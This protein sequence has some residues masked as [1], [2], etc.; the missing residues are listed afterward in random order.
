MGNELG[1]QYIMDGN[2]NYY[3]LGGNGQLIVAKDRNEAAVFT[4][5]EANQ[6]IGD[7]KKAKFYYTIPVEEIEETEKEMSAG[8]GEIA[9]VTCADDNVSKVFNIVDKMQITAKEQTEENASSPT[10]QSQSE[11]AIPVTPVKPQPNFRYSM[12]DTDWNE[13]VNYYIFLASNIKGYQE[14]LTKQESDIDKTICDLLHYV[15][16]YDLTDEEGLRAMDLLKDARQRRRDVKNELCKADY[17]QKSI[18]SSANVAKAKGFLTQLKK[19]DTQ[20]Y[21]PR[22]LSELFVGMHERATDRDAYRQRR[23]MKSEEEVSGAELTQENMEEPEMSYAETV[24]DQKENDWLGFA[25]Q[26][27]EFY[28]NAGQYMMNLQ[29]EIDTIDQEIENVMEKI[30]DANYNVAQGYKVFKELKDLRNERKSKAQEL[31]VLRTMTECFDLDAMAEVWEYNV[32]EVE[33]MTGEKSNE[34]EEQDQAKEIAV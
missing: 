12:E 3:T 30:E 33:N 16:L 25:R 27:V 2:G 10:E 20:K 22:F 5:S 19:L 14:E 18:G 1:M 17:F 23:Q 9:T 21:H 24:Y 31:E 4:F 29:I 8:S 7:G 28:R 32:R 34:A 13:F 15:E 26:Q 6:K 11:I